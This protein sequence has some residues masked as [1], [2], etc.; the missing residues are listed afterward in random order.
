MPSLS[1]W[2]L[3]TFASLPGVVILAAL[4]STIFF[5]LPFGIDAV[6]A[7][8]AARRGSLAWIVPL[9]A[10]AGSIAG[11]ALTFAMGV[12]IGDHGL[13][14]YVPPNRLARIRARIRDSGA[15]AL[16]VLD[17]IPP[18]FPFTPFVLAAGALEVKGV[19]FFTTLAVCRLLRFGLV[20]AL[21]ARYGTSILHLLESHHVHDVVTVFIVI[22]A[23]LTAWSLY[24]VVRAAR[25][26]GRRSARR[27]RARAG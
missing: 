7:I 18:P 2:V 27:V 26:S 19:T 14:R 20:A 25:T 8:V 22:A 1:R 5:S 17:L 11:A 24:T 13:E 6:V 4:D 16:A 23:A 15:I 21:G 10:T 9:L 12:K 3:G